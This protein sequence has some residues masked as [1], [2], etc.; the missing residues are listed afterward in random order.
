MD[1]SATARNMAK[2]ALEKRAVD[3]RAAKDS[4]RTY[5][6]VYI[7]IYIYIRYIENTMYASVNCGGR[8]ALLLQAIAATA[9]RKMPAEL[10]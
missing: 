10:V 9:L 5:I 1:G 7:Y 4:T 6:Y 8:R 2:L 3:A